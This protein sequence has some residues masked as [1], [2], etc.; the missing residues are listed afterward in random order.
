M[1]DLRTA[2][3]A[4]TRITEIEVLR[5]NSVAPLSPAEFIGGAAGRRIE[6]LRRRGKYL[7][8]FLEDGWVLAAHF[9]MS[10]SF[11]LV[12]PE[13]PRDSHDRLVL[14]LIF[15]GAET[16]DTTPAQSRRELRFHDPRAFGRIKLIAD[17][18]EVSTLL[19]P[20]PLDPAMTDTAFYRLLRRRRQLKT[21]LLDQRVLVGLG[22]IYTDEALHTAGLHPLRRAD[23]LSLTDASRLLS[24]IRSVLVGAIEQR[25]TSLGDGEGSY[26][27]AGREGDNLHH[28]SVY[29]RTGCACPCCGTAVQRIVVGQRGT[30]ICPRC[31]PRGELSRERISDDLTG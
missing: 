3:V 17:E 1:R 10:G 26:R 22:N 29:G 13:T 24:A 2:G 25:G 18:R 30:H 4:G 6:A 15:P 27:S 12:A 31:Q 21:L 19:G 9:R 7:L 23:T 20:E 11:T 8:F 14:S 5:Q 28:L 16:T